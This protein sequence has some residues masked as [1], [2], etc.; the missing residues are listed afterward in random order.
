M[1]FLSHSHAD[2]RYVHELAFELNQRGHD[3]W[4]DETHQMLGDTLWPPIE[5]AIHGSEVF[6]LVASETSL[7]SPFVRKEIGLA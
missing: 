7:A 2:R 3:V 1:I 5:D 4:V 6:L